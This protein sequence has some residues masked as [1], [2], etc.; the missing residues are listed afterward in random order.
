MALYLNQFKSLISQSQFERLIKSLNSDKQQGQFSSL[1]QF[2][3][4]L[5]TLSKELFEKRIA[6]LLKLFLGVPGFIIDTETYN[7]ML[8]RLQDDL[9]VAFQEAKNIDEVLR[10]HQALVKDLI[11]KN[12][13]HAVSDLERQIATH[14]L[15]VTSPH[16]FNKTLFSNFDGIGTMRF[17]RTVET[18]GLFVDPRENVLMPS[19]FD[20]S[21]DEIG[22]YLT[23]PFQ[24]IGYIPIVGIRQIFDSE[25]VVTGYSVSSDDLKLSNLIDDLSNTYW[26][27]L[28]LFEVNQPTVV[29]TKLEL[30]LGGTQEINF[31]EIEPVL[32]NDVVLQEIDYLDSNGVLE[33]ID[34]EEAI[35]N[36]RTKIQFQKI[37]ASKIILIFRNENS[38]QVNYVVGQKDQSVDLPDVISPLLAQRLQLVSDSRTITF[39][40]RQFQ[41]GFDN[42]RVGLA[43]FQEAGIFI[44]EELSLGQP[45]KLV[46]LKTEEIRPTAYA[47][48]PLDFSPESDTYD[49]LSDQKIF[50]GSIEYWILR[51]QFS[52]RQE[53]LSFNVFPILPLGITR[54][55]HERLILTHHFSANTLVNDSGRLMFY[56]DPDSVESTLA[57]F[58]NGNSLN[59]IDDE[60][61][62]DGWLIEPRLTNDL[63]SSGSPMK[64]G[65][66]LSQPRA[67]DIYTVSYTPTISNILTTAKASNGNEHQTL[68]DLVGDLSARSYLDQVVLN[69]ET[70]GANQV[71]GTTVCLM[72]VLRRNNADGNLS[73]IVKNFILAIGAKDLTRFEDQLYG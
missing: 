48:A 51:K 35:G 26:S 67:G 27:Q 73:P 18:E 29:I 40:G 55:N 5:E 42:I 6:P 59:Q 4:R 38:S 41:I 20:A 43:T 60:S 71:A 31:V 7:F 24:N 16:G 50:A 2:R 69:E 54:I 66:R 53:L 64:F 23:L 17:Q 32:L 28:Y 49:D 61:E 37:A 58:R 62:G 72:I 1:D 56:I 10:S 12:L 14:E 19:A 21:I 9:E 46:G 30:D 33:T 25:A 11:L 68:V 65:I 13:K 70:T 22:K 47:S 34:T 63:L 44:S 36:H 45:M 57:V 39:S 52:D 8:D 3:T 15:I